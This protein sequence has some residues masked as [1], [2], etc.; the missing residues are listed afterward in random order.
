MAKPVGQESIER[1]AVRSILSAA[2]VLL[3]LLGAVA[4][5]YAQA[6]RLDIGAVSRN[7]IPPRMLIGDW[8]TIIRIDDRPQ[9]VRLRIH[10]IEPGQ[11]AGKL[12]YASPKRC[13]VDL[14]YGGPNG[15]EHIFYIV[16][17]TNCF[18]YGKADYIALVAA[19]PVSGASS[20]LTRQAENYRK[21]SRNQEASAGTSDASS[22]RKAPLEAP[23]IEIMQYVVNLGGERVELG[24]L[25][26]Q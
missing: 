13:T 10:T 15:D 11:T 2:V 12:I 9:P 24:L 16:P 19:E 20:D 22:G 4:P 14:E 25:T 21:M 5:A 6:A 3:G 23:K 18:R 7:L 8:L 26:R 17:F 1:G